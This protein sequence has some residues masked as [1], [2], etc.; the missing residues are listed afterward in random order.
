MADIGRAVERHGVP[1]TTILGGLFGFSLVVPWALFAHFGE[2]RLINVLSIVLLTGQILSL[3]LMVTAVAE[4]RHPVMLVFAIFTFLCF[5]L[6]TMAL[7]ASPRGL[8]DQFVS[9]ATVADMNRALT[10]ALLGMVCSGLG[11][12]AG[13]RMTRW[14]AGDAGAAARREEPQDAMAPRLSVVAASILLFAVEL[15]KV[16]EYLH[17]GMDRHS[18][19]AAH[20]SHFW[21]LYYTILDIDTGLI[22]LLVLAVSQWE[23]LGRHARVLTGLAV[24]GYGA[25]RVIMSSKAAVFQVVL[26]WLFARLAQDRE[27]RTNRTLIALAIPLLV[28][29]LVTFN[30]ARAIRQHWEDVRN[31]KLTLYDTYKDLAAVSP[32]NYFNVLPL[33]NRLEGIDPLVN[34]VNNKG[35]DTRQHVNLVNEAKSLVTHLLPTHPLRVAW[36]AQEYAVVFGEHRE[37]EYLNRSL[38]TTYIWTLWGEF[39]VLFGAA[40]G[41]LASAAAM[42]VLVALYGQAGR[43]PGLYRLLARFACLYTTYALLLSF[44]LDFLAWQLLQLAAAGM[45]FFAILGL[46]RRL[47]VR[48]LTPA[49]A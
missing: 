9:P 30:G 13:A 38:Y 10:Y 1:L 29:A 22:V 49:A 3:L 16:Y 21:K 26:F 41:L 23:S 18:Q 11:I 47:R 39:Y 27:L 46:L 34:V 28:M 32:G 8:F 5:P 7:I 43:L 6:R 31:Q 19:A 37:E 15:N 45:F 2:N 14:K 36:M 44:G 25:T 33:L 42:A 17:I 40:G 20:L 12:V 48:R 24:V 4:K 35:V